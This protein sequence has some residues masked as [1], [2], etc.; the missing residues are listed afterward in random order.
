[1]AVEVA[2]TLKTFETPDGFRVPAE[3]LVAAGTAPQVGVRVIA[4]TVQ[5]QAITVFMRQ[6]EDSPFIEGV[7]IISSDVASVEGTIVEVGRASARY[8]SAARSASSRGNTAG[9]LLV[10]NEAQDIDPDVWDAVFAPMAA[11]TNATTLFLGTVWTSDTLLARQMRLLRDR[12]Y[13]EES[14]Y[15]SSAGRL[16]TRRTRMLPAVLGAGEP[17]YVG[18]FTALGLRFP[19]RACFYHGFSDE[20]AHLIVPDHG[21]RFW[22]LVNRYPMTERA[23]GFLIAKG[24]EEG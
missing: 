4:Y 17:R 15:H 20:L 13:A 12:V 14:G 22:D 2:Q 11:S 6:L 9:L 5:A 19:G 16:A 7:T 24:M 21:E 18:F 3:V 23:R 10:A 8:L 1:M